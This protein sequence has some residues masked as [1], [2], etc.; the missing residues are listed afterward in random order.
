MV[1]PIK[2]NELYAGLAELNG[3]VRMEK[4]SLVL[5]YNLKDDVLGMFNSELKVLK[6]PFHA[7][8]DVIVK[9]KWFSA[10]FDLYLNRLPNTDKTIDVKGN[11]LSFIIK[12]AE[13][14][15]ARSLRSTLM[16]RVSEE[17]LRR[18]DEEEEKNE[19]APD[20]SGFQFYT[21]KETPG[22]G[23]KNMLREE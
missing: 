10:R 16:L 13:L 19:T 11:C 20:P 17:R 12:K 21:R 14:E 1:L 4:D 2:Q 6:I 7:I 9:K 23:L 22:S 5:E 15:K 8:E 18:I 3:L